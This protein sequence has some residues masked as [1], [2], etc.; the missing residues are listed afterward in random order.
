MFVIHLYSSRDFIMQIFPSLFILRLGKF[1]F[2]FVW[3]LC[4]FLFFFLEVSFL[5]ILVFVR[6][7]IRRNMHSGNRFYFLTP[8]IS[9]DSFACS[10][11]SNLQTTR[12][13]ITNFHWNASWMFI[14]T[15]VLVVSDKECSTF[16]TA[17]LFVDKRGRTK[18]IN[19][20]LFGEGE[21]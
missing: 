11:L 21:K 9:A 6:K 17:C 7:C 15:V 1:P 19:I 13:L 8:F 12:P 5:V 4:R 14:V 3:L 2:S 18:K 10:F 16:S 20:R